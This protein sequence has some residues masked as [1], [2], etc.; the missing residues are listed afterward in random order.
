MRE[1]LITAFEPFDGKTE[2]A[3]FLVLRDL[4]ERI[5]GYEVRKTVL[6]VVFGK[7]ADL[8]KTNGYDF[9]FLLGEAG[10]DR[11]TPETTAR[12]LRSARIPDNEGNKPEHE[13]IMEGGPEQYRTPIQVQSIVA[14]MKDEGYLVELSDDAGTFVCN[15]TFYLV[16]TGN[17]IPVEFIHV[18]VTK[19]DTETVRR[20]IELAL[21]RCVRKIR[22]PS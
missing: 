3:S 21:D 22:D 7:A 16:G 12:N 11:V 14:Q 1:I 5:G 10:R 4:P 15:D 13:I 2:N 18:P 8:V 17:A 9:V 6:P 20:F 19:P